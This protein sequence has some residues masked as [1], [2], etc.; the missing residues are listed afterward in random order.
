[1]TVPWTSLYPRTAYAAGTRTAGVYTPGATTVT[2]VRLNIQPAPGRVVLNLEEG[3]R[4]RNAQ[5]VFSDVELNT[6]TTGA[7]STLPDEITYK[8]AQYE[9]QALKDWQQ[10]PTFTNVKH[11]EYLALRQN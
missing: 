11:F 1:M 2:N 6:G 8:S 10:M 5:I 3:D 4:T 7:S 9:I